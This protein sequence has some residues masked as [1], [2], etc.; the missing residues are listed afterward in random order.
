M[1]KSS[2]DSL[3][4]CIAF[5]SSSMTTLT[6]QNGEWATLPLLLRGWYRFIISKS[7]IWIYIRR[8]LS[9][10][11]NRS[12]RARQKGGNGRV[13][14]V[15][16]PQ[17]HRVSRICRATRGYCTLLPSGIPNAF[18]EMRALLS[19]SS[20]NNVAVVYEY[21]GEQKCTFLVAS[22]SRFLK[23]ASQAPRIMLYETRAPLPR[24][25][26]KCNCANESARCQTR[27]F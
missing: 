3:R 23:S 19:A 27:N 1:E 18:R 21:Y 8:L 11:K 5:S 9:C 17:S 10:K 12:N 16:L 20:R 14:I 26:D 6:R 15:E 4:N 2:R 13:R 24:I 7:T 25:H 22:F